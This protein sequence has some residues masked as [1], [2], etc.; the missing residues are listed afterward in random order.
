[1]R[2]ESVWII[3]HPEQERFF[4]LPRP[5]S[6]TYVEAMRKQGY[7]VFMTQ[8]TF[9]EDFGVGVERLPESTGTRP[10]WSTRVIVNAHDFTTE[11]DE[12]AYE[13]L[14]GLVGMKGQPTV[15]CNVDGHGFTLQ[16]GRRT[17]AVDG[18]IVSVAHTDNA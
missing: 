14:V 10:G 15:V 18:M 12:L 9:P 17:K 11:L 16:P 13:D 7:R 3:A 4:T 1:M 5:P 6:D 8:V 2:I